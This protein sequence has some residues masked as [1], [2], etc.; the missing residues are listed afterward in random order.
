MMEEGILAQVNRETYFEQEQLFMFT[1][2][3]KRG[4]PGEESWADL[5]DLFG[6]EMDRNTLEEKLKDRSD[7]F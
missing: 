2:F 1:A 3:E 7:L 5:N 6:Q 4:Q